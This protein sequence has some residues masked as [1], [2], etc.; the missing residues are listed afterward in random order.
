MS[1][2]FVK[3]DDDFETAKD[4]VDKFRA[5]FDKPDWRTDHL[6]KG[7]VESLL[8]LMRAAMMQIRSLNQMNVEYMTDDQVYDPGHEEHVDAN[9]RDED[10]VDSSAR[11]NKD[12]VAPT[13]AREARPRRQIV[14][15]ERRRS[16]SRRR[17]RTPPG[18]SASRS[19]S[20]ASRSRATRTA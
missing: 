13:V 19:R 16:R 20:R 18:A 10:Y 8:S 2:L 3:G 15:T 14:N 9:D 1:F 12:A 17:S 4:T 6:P 5:E 7:R 11:S